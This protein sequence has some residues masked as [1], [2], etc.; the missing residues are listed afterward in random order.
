MYW[1][2]TMG[3][4]EVNLYLDVWNRNKER[5]SIEN[6]CMSVVLTRHWGASCVL[7]N[8]YDCITH[9]VGTKDIK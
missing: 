1:G 8:L 7:I 2:S 5:E 4:T 6:S 3:Y 9:S